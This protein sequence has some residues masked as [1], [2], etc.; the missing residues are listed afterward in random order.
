MSLKAKDLVGLWKQ[1]LEFAKEIK[2]T[3][4]F[5]GFMFWC[6]YVAPFNGL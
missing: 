3:E 5:E 2:E 4:S 1:Y 6:E